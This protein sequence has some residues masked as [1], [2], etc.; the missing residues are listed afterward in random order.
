MTDRLVDALKGLNELPKGFV[1]RN[2]D[3]SPMTDNQIKN[4]CNQLCRW[5]GI[6]EFGWHTLRHG[7]GTHAGLFGV[8][9]WT[10]MMWL[11][12][13]R[14]DETMIYVN[15]A[16]AHRRP[17]PEIILA[18]ADDERDP[19]T[20]IMKMLGARGALVAT[21]VSVPNATSSCK[22]TAT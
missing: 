6:R 12:H 20:R 1:I 18:A 13:K 16:N 2:P 10:L 15:L 5:A 3:G 11:G 17:I 4:V 19:D 21:S 22:V 8:N 14:V 7:F 9:P